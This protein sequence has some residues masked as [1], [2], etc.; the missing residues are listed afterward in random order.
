MESA[1]VMPMYASQKGKPIGDILIDLGAN[2]HHVRLAIQQ[3]KTTRIPLPAV[4][5]DMG[6]VSSEKLAEA[7]ALNAGYRY[8]SY[9]AA[10]ELDPASLIE[11]K[12]MLKSFEKF[13]IIGKESGRLRVAI[14]SLDSVNT[15][16]NH[17]IN[18][19]V[20]INIA[21]YS[22]IQHVY[23]RHFA[24]TEAEFD[25]ALANYID[26][27]NKG[28]EKDNAGVISGLIGRAVRHA[29]YVGAS[30]IRFWS[31]GMAGQI[32]L[33]IDGNG[34][35]FRS[36]PLDAFDSAMNLLTMNA[37][38]ANQMQTQHHQ[39]AKFKL[40]PT[41]EGEFADILTRYTFRMQISRSND[42]KRDITIRINDNQSA[43]VDFDT[44]GY[45]EEAE[46]MIRKAIS[47]PNGLVIVTGPTGSGKTTT[48]YSIL[49]EIDPI[50]RQIFTIEHP[51]EYTHGM[52]IQNELPRGENEGVAAREALKSLLRKAPKIILMGE[53]RDDRE[54]VNTCIAAANT[55][56]L[57]FTTMHTNDAV[58]TILR[59]REWGASNE[60]LAS[61]L[62]LV[63]AQ[64]L[65][66]VL[67]KHCKTPD[68]RQHVLHELEDI[69]VK[70]P[71]RAV[72]C[73]HCNHTGYRGRKMLYEI[74]P[75]KNVRELVERNA[76]MS[77]IE[78]S[79]LMGPNMWRRGLEMVAD[80]ITSMD[81]LMLRTQAD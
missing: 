62:R 6:L 17:L 54:L 24:N 15:V 5:R 29:C 68:S 65:V 14:E 44:L 72:G 66:G 41:V 33:E 12:P 40:D 71:Y 35:M 53:L 56:H 18:T 13:V 39:E 19:P 4:V 45:G 57:V 26:M 38:V 75:A 59:F 48:L 58:S 7:I 37:G 2:P 30:D 78:R 76:P 25:L 31:T 20:E 46:S 42:R 74:M 77:E 69:P 55:G 80:G 51:I 16:R 52:W 23:R 3:H 8:F 36:I 70:K 43:D 64:R 63:I 9:T 21:S 67:C 32:K 28:T 79:A 49:R 47:S 60:G 81:E 34:T 50:T 61:V 27:V 22:T 11:F 73:P 1:T 10:K